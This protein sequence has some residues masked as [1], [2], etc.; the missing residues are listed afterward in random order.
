[1]ALKVARLG[2]QASLPAE[3][4]WAHIFYTFYESV[5]KKISKMWG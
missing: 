3:P 5:I 4:S 2:E 1:M